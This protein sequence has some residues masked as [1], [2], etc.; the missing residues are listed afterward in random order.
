MDGLRN[1]LPESQPGLLFIWF[2]AGDFPFDF[3]ES[4]AASCL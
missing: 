1:Y 4:Q 2:V 3:T